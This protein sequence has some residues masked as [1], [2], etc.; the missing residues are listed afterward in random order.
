MCT[1]MPVNF[2]S[3][4]R[5]DIECTLKLQ[6]KQTNKKQL[7]QLQKNTLKADNILDCFIL[8][9]KTASIFPFEYKRTHVSQVLQLFSPFSLPDPA[10]RPPASIVTTN[11]EPGTGYFL[12]IL[13]LHKSHNTP[14][15]PP[16]IVHNPCLQFL[17][18]HEGV[19]RVIENNAYFFFFFFFWGGGG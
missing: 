9:L 10:R 15:L 17:I 3:C 4:S 1:S 5:K 7:K 2:I 11:R 18:R 16:K 6:N 8:L 19:P 13:Y 12:T 14:L